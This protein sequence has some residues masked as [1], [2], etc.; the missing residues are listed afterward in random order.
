MFILLPPTVSRMIRKAKDSPRITVGKLKR[1]VGFWGDQVS[2]TTVRC[3]LHANKFG[4]LSL[5]FAK[6]DRNFDRNCVL[7]PDKTE[8]GLLGNQKS[9]GG[10][11]KGPGSLVRVHGMMTSMKYQD[12]VF[13][14]TG[15]LWILQQD[16][17]PK[18][19]SKSTQKWL[20]EHKTKLRPWPS[21]SPD[22]NLS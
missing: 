6:C 17:D 13:T 20:T 15:L 18:H 5:E 1:K 9:R 19:T 11:S 10:S 2:K 14:K 21:Q 16:N 7:Y 12:M 4:E 3:H 22:L 8:I